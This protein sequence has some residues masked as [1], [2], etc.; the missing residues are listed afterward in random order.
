MHHFPANI[1]GGTN[2]SHAIAHGRSPSLQT[3]LE[4]KNSAWRLTLQ[5]A[6]AQE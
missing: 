6:A 2:Y 3:E 1:A 5:T 4:V